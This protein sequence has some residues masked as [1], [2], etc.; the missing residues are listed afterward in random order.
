VPISYLELVTRDVPALNPSDVSKTP[1]F[2]MFDMP[3]GFL[4]APLGIDDG[5]DHPP[6]APVAAGTDSDLAGLQVNLGMYNP[7]FD[8]HL[9][10]DP[11]KLG[12]YRLYSQLQLVDQRTT[13]VCLN[14]N[15]T[16]P[17]GVQFGGLAQGPTVASQSLSWFQDLGAGTALQGYV[18]QSIQANSG[19]RDNLHEGFHYGMALQY[20]LPPVAAQQTQNLYV[21]VQALGR[22]RYDGV[23]TDNHA[24]FW[25][26]MPGLHWRWNTNS[27]LSVG[28]SHYNFLTCAWQF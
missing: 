11:G 7:N 6:D 12:Y 14:V 8:L 18:G 20:P 17:A 23:T 25:E 28:V 13:S 9:P 4:A 10:G 5:D 26:V 2:R 22:Y 1:R 3:S 24:A 16:G 15:S 19:W 27:W 21:F